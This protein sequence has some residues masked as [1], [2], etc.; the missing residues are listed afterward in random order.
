MR[1]NTIVD[2]V[3]KYHVCHIKPKK[4]QNMLLKCPK[5]AVNF[6]NCE[7]NVIF[8]EKIIFQFLFTTICSILIINH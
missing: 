4:Y 1:Y 6:E 2:F 5:I 7:K 8:D 3:Q